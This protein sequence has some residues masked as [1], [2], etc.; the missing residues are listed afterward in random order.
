VCGG[1]LIIFCTVKDDLAWLKEEE[2]EEEEEGS[3]P[4]KE[5]PCVAFYKCA[6]LMC[7]LKC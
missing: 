2:E 4:A 5:S 3:Q 1:R 7:P 6:F